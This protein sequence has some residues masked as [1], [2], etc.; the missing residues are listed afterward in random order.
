[1]RQY[2]IGSADVP[3]RTSIHQFTTC[4]DRLLFLGLRC[5]QTPEED[6]RTDQLARTYDNLVRR[7][8]NS[9]QLN[10]LLASPSGHPAFPGSCL[11]GLID[12]PP[13]C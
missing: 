11:P 6:R 13:H 2:A 1:M 10:S 8:P 12:T 4:S 3:M 5:Q 7:R 9:I